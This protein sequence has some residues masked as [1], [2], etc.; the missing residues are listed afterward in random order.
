MGRVLVTGSHGFLGAH[1][2]RRLCAAGNEVVAVDNMLGCDP[3]TLKGVEGAITLIEDAANLGAWSSHHYM[4]RIELAYLLAATPHEGL[5]VFSP[6]TVCRNTYL[7]TIGAAVAAINAGVKRI[8]FCSSMARYGDLPSKPFRE[9]HVPMPVDPYGIAKLAAENTLLA[10]GQAHNVEIVIIVPHNIYGPGQ[11]Y[12]DPFR[13]VVGIMMNL[14]LQGRQPIIYGDGEQRRCFSFVDDCVEP[15]I[16][17]GFK[18]GLDH[19][20]YNIG[21]DDEFVTINY[22]AELIAEVLG[23][24]D[25]KPQYVPA[26]PMEVK[27]AYCSADLARSDLG[28]QPKTQLRLGLELMAEWVKQKGTRAFDYHLPIDIKSDKCPATWKERLF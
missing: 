5:S 18:H 8:V 19:V 10:L 15:M 6:Y 28:Y 9:Y 4:K 3:D 16:R 7:S 27:H 24:P 2:V 17:A 11:R 14:M 20:V 21:P 23:F 26:R 22:L 13:N 1:L 12:H 25:L